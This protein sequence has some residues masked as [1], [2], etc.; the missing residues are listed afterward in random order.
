[1]TNYKILKKYSILIVFGIILLFSL[2]IIYLKELN[3][4]SASY[5]EDTPETTQSAEDIVNASYGPDG[6]P[7]M[8]T[9]KGC[10]TPNDLVGMCIDYDLCCSSI[11]ETN[12][13][14]C[15][16]PFLQSCKTSYDAC[17]NDPTNQSMYP[18]KKQITEKCSTDNAA[19]CKKYNN[20]PLKSTDFNEPVHRTQSDNIIC[21]MS[22]VKNIES[23]CL[24]FCQTRPECVAY[25][26]NTMSCNLYS[27]ISP[28]VPKLDSEGRPAENSS[29]NYYIKK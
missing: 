13:C 22:S 6:P 26:S 15:N 16:H 21:N 17:M 5:F 28:Y 19:C 18:S 3:K 25:S 11:S 2:L 24:E 27:K 4:K 10:S 9:A 20:I 1:M 14:F 8:G 29:I 7:K 12:K 23:K